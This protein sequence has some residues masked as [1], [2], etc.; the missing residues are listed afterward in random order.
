[1]DPT[2]RFRPAYGLRE[3]GIDLVEP[4]SNFCGPRC[5]D[6]GVDFRVEA[7]DQFASNGGALLRRQTQRLE[8]N[9]S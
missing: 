6:V 3:T 8:K 2:T 1:V 9:I 4:G 7:L 5:L